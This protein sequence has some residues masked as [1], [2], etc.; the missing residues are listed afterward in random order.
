M[1]TIELVP[2]TA[3]G[4]NL[5]SELPKT[6][7]D[8]LRRACYKKAGYVCE[9]CGGVGPTHPVEC[10]EI[11]DYDDV[12]RI[13]TL[14]GLIALCP[15]CHQVKHIGYA[16]VMGKFNEARDHL[17]KVNNWRKKNTNQYIEDAFMTWAQ[18][19]GVKWG[20]DTS[21]VDKQE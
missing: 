11:W 15:K 19:S 1:L 17:M 3:W 16:Q 14:T 21:W 2:K 7:W 9:V 12:Q 18:R 20:V 6:Q 10:H 8:V 4:T 13:Q 5:R